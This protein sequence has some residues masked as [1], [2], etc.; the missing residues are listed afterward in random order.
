[1]DKSLTK[2]YIHTYDIQIV[3]EL[4]IPASA[5]L[6]LYADSKKSAKQFAISISLLIIRLSRLT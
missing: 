6:C 5:S 1:M 2:D 3:N 4:K